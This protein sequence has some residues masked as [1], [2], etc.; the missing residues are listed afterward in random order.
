MKEDLKN[1]LYLAFEAPEPVEKKTFLKRFSH[2]RISNA[3]FMLFQA[4]YIPKGFWMFTTFVF[5]VALVGACGLK[6]D[7]LWVISSL[8]PFVALSAVAENARSSVYYMAELERATRFSLKSVILARMGIVGIVHMLLLC[9]LLPLGH[10]YSA[11]SFVET[12]VYMLLPYLAST[13]SGLWITRKMRG[14]EAIYACAGF[15][16]LVSGINFVCSYELFF[17]HRDQ[18][19]HGYVIALMILVVMAVREYRQTILETEELIWSL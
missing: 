8:L 3:K 16:V 10:M 12:G 17:D 6:R 19:F 9:M 1:A 11:M 13:V 18:Y 14:K 7:M 4:A 5:G 2:P 15:A